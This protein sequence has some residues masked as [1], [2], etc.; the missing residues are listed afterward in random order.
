MW[1]VVVA[2]P[3]ERRTVPRSD[4]HLAPARRP[5]RRVRTT[6]GRDPVA[7]VQPHTVDRPAVLA[8]AAVPA[9]SRLGR[10]DVDRRRGISAQNRV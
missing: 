4:Q 10:A 6:V 5:E 1:P 9:G 3:V 2:E 8:E 7:G